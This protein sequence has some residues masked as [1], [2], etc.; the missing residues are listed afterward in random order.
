MTKM[1][2]TNKKLKEVN[3]LL[4]GVPISLKEL[5]EKKKTIDKDHRIVL[6]ENNSYRT[7]QKLED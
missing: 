7:L 3:V 5:E 4:D 1:A 6:V 2:D